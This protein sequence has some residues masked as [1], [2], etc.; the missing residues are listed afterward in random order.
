M[1]SPH[2]TSSFI[3]TFSPKTLGQYSETIKLYLMGKSYQI[4]LVL[5]GSSS[6]ISDKIIKN[7]GPEG[8]PLDFEYTK[9]FL[10]ENK[11]IETFN[12]KRKGDRLIISTQNSNV[13]QIKEND[14][15]N[16]DK[17]EDL[18]A[19]QYNK[20]KYN[21]FLKSTRLSRLQRVKTA[22]L[23]TKLS[24]I[25]E[26]RRKLGLL[27]KE[28][29]EEKDSIP[30]Q[31]YEFM[32]GLYTSDV[33]SEKLPLPLGKDVLFVKKPIDKYEPV[34]EV[35]SQCFNPDPNQ[36]IKKKFPSSPKSHAEIRDCNQELTGAM[37]QKIYAGP[38]EINFGN[39]YLKSTEVKTFSVR[40]DLRSSILVRMV[41][42]NE[43]LKDSYT[44]AQVIGSSQTAG[45]EVIFNSKN[46]QQF[47]GIVKYIINERHFFEFK[48]VALVDP[49]KL[50]LNIKTLEFSFADDSLEMEKNLPLRIFNKGN[51]SG[52][53]HWIMAER[54]IFTIR[55]S[56]GE[57]PARSFLDVMVTY[58][59]TGNVFGNKPEEERL[60]MKVEDGNEEII[61]CYGLVKEM[62]C[63]CKQD[64]L[65]LGQIPVC[66]KSDKN[67][68][69]LK[70]VFK[71]TAVFQISLD[72][73]PPYLEIL[74]LREKIMPDETKSLKVSF[75]C[76]EELK[77]D[78]D[79]TVL[80]RGGKSL[81]IP[82]KVET[83][84]PKVCILEDELNFGEVTTLG[85]SSSLKMS[86]VNYSNIPATLILDLRDRD[87][88]PKE[89]EGVDCID[90]EPLREN[91]T[92]AADQSSVMVSLNNSFSKG[93]SKYFRYNNFLKKFI[94]GWES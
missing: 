64:V 15:E 66:K 39:I 23:K 74:P 8:V 78:S 93:A 42:E 72:K 41:V 52:K 88:G 27:S 34:M 75:F 28:D 58:K 30:P 86:L 1:F 59:P 17:F 49:V 82:F 7:R 70:N 94:K 90:I 69:Y 62:K 65:D 47:K 43:E 37:L 20:N 25:N 53:F 89:Y 63:I 11:T 40:N 31:D 5:K 32:F 21:E 48:V 91:K 80:F 29:E 14:S 33:K 18:V 24:E 54:K 16:E 73:L 44:Q 84:L 83:I 92:D 45:F 81:V 13:F 85:T 38:I 77:M 60:R 3:M 50:E 76:K 71:N 46:V 10:D 87:D 61:K 36:R 79:I 67:Y 26:Q 4:P 9:H 6:K 55:P 68:I 51:S 56:E 22:N 2:Q 57:V 12:K 35:Q 19:K